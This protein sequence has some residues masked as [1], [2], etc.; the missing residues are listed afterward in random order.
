M[1]FLFIKIYSVL[2][3]I[4][5]KNNKDLQYLICKPDYIFYIDELFSSSVKISSASNL[6]LPQKSGSGLKLRQVSGLCGELNNLHR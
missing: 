4:I 6:F 3:F 5:V 2:Q 1:Q